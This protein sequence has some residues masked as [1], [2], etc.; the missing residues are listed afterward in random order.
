L[1]ASG[2]IE[3]KRRDQALDWMTFLLDEGF[4]QWFYTNPQVKAALPGL[5][6]EVEKGTT[7]PTAAAD[8]LLGFLDGRHGKG[9]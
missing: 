8:I 9:C 4:R 6:A 2:E 1:T 3:K 5:R 7:S